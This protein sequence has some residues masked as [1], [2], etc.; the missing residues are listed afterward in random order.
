MPHTGI[1]RF[2]VNTLIWSISFDSSLVP[3]EKLKEAGVDGD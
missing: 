3:F 1:M 2:G